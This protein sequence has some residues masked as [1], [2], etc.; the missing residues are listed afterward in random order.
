MNQQHGG[1]A[2][3]GVVGPSQT[4]EQQILDRWN[5]YDQTEAE[6]AQEGILPEQLP[7]F[8]FPN[9]TREL[10]TAPDHETYADACRCVNAWLSYVE[11]R[12]ADTENALAM[13]NR[14]QRDAE[15]LIRGK[16]LNA[17]PEGSKA[18]TLKYQDSLIQSSPTYRELDDDIHRLEH[19]LRKYRA[20][21]NGYE[22][23]AKF[24]S[25]NIELKR[26][27][28]ERGHTTGASRREPSFPGR[29]G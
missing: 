10:I 28:W 2:L 26:M 27:S 20:K 29:M 25:R 23:D 7:T 14:Q 13:R 5:I 11:E 19:K 16:I 4:E 6:L 9:I 8:V 22:R 1:L 3:P 21:F 12:I 15:D 18:P 24:L 17:V